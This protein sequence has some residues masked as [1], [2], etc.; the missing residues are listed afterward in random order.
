M[1][2]KIL[3][4]MYTTRALFL[5]I[6]VM[7]MSVS[8]IV[9]TNSLAATQSTNNLAS[10][11]ILL[12]FNEEP[13]NI[14]LFSPIFLEQVPAPQ[15]KKII[16]ELKLSFGVLKSVDVVD[17]KGFAYFEK[18][19]VP[20]TIGFDDN[21]Q[22]STLWF[23]SPKFIN[24]KLD[25]AIKNLQDSAI[26]SKSL[27]ITID[28]KPI[29]ADNNKTPMA[30]G[31]TFK[32][33]V[34]KAY[35][36]AIKAGKI[37]RDDVILLEENSRSLPSGVL[38]M[39]PAKTPINLEILAQLM[40]Q[41]SDNTATDNLIHLLKKSNIEIFSPRNSPLLTTREF[42][43]LI[44][45]NNDELRAKYSTSNQKGKNEILLGLDKL[46]LP[47]IDDI[48]KTATW[49][50]AE[51]YMT[52]NEICATLES[53]KDAPALNNIH[54]PLFKNLNWKKIGFKGGSENGV[55]NFSFIGQT[56]QGKD[57][58]VVFTAN[59]DDKQPESKLALQFIGLLQTLSSVEK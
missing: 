15:L 50:Q 16:A 32:L 22:I 42:F 40:I 44:S 53:I 51:W 38:Q 13:L 9:A 33:L 10:N 34:L 24:V 59:G 35:E 57:V 18:A 47:D 48:T 7:V 25:E 17:G 52:T 11:K 23:G 20:V 3:K 21:N 46:P 29:F 54:N 58:C 28:K 14:S 55:L 30:V 12:I 26:G 4:K 49:Q 8:P 19:Q 39:L 31:S 36:E 56:L 6:G 37:K 5:A 2:R 45:S 43:Q 41:S 1:K 27:L